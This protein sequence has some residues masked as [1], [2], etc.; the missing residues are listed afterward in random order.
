[1]TD[2]SRDSE[3]PGEGHELEGVPDLASISEGERATGCRRCVLLGVGRLLERG[4]R[5]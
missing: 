2:D 5:G 3:G 4:G 1:M